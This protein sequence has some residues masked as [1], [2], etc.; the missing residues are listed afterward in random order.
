MGENSYKMLKEVF[1]VEST[2]KNI[3][4]VINNL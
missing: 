3:L 4:E 2:V 1:S